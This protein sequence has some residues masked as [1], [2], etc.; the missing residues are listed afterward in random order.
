[1]N[2]AARLA[3]FAAALLAVFV[4]AF[5]VGRSVGPGDQSIPADTSAPDSSHSPAPQEGSGDEHP[6]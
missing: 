1:M 3:A 2:T 4:L 5:V 6:H